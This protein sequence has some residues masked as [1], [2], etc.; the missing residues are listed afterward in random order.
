MA[1]KLT[2]CE[3]QQRANAR[4]ANKASRDY[5]KRSN[6]QF[7]T[8]TRSNHRAKQGTWAWPTKNDGSFDKR[9]K[10]NRKT[11]TPKRRRRSK[12]WTSDLSFGQIIFGGGAIWL[13]LLAL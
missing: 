12:D 11:R 7:A 9:C 2:P 6:R 8:A 13:F 3:K 1:K 5:T 4:A 10:L